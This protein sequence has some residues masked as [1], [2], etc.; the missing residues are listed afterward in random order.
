[1]ARGEN[2]E[3]RMYIQKILEY[4]LLSKDEEEKLFIAYRNG[5]LDAGSKLIT[6]NL[7]LVLSIASSWSRNAEEKSE[8][9][10][11]GNLVL[12]KCVRSFDPNK[13]IS[14]STYATKSIVNALISYRNNKALIKKPEELPR[15][16]KQ[17]EEGE[18]SSLDKYGYIDYDY[19]SSLMKTRK[20]YIYGYKNLEKQFESLERKIEDDEESRTLGESIPS[21]TNVEEEVIS[22]EMIEYLRFLI[23]NNFSER[24]I[25]MLYAVFSNEIGLAKKTG[26]KYNIQRTQVYNEADKMVKKLKRIING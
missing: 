4:P 22:K 20:E 23:H 9:I 8:F 15:K 21:D 14:F 3:D 18:S 17:I 19:V 10:C 11:E 6:S 1:M 5:D 16:L 13:N 2:M 24:E 25:E 26:D 7:R 12:V